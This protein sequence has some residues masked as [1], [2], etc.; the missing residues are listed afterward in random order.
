MLANR[1]SWSKSAP[2]PIAS[3]TFAA[4]SLTSHWCEYTDISSVPE[5]GPALPRGRDPIELGNRVAHHVR[6][7]HRRGLLDALSGEKALGLRRPWPRRL[8]SGSGTCRRLSWP[9]GSHTPPDARRQSELRMCTSASSGRR[10][11]AVKAAPQ[12]SAITRPASFSQRRRRKPSRPNATAPSCRRCYF[13]RCGAKSCATLKVSDFRHAR[14]G[15]PHLKLE[16]KGE[17]TRY[18]PIHRAT[19]MLSPTGDR[20]FESSSLQR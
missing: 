12:Q 5:F 11:R 18:V 10:P 9:D 13:T 20:G 15:V 17:K 7:Q 14:R 19:K 1:K 4:I 3:L 6:R 8:R 16:G 2:S